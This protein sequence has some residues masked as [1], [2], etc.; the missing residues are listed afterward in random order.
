[1][2]HHRP[3]LCLQRRFLD[4]A[5]VQIVIDTLFKTLGFTRHWCLLPVILTTQEAEIRR[6]LS[7]K[8][9]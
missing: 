8:T 7:Q 5:Q 1:L 4:W 2:L 9:Y 6:I 3:K